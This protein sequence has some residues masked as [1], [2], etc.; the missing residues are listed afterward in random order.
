MVK[1]K[2]EILAVSNRGQIKL[3]SGMLVEYDALL[4]F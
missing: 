1:A 2:C 3:P 4:E